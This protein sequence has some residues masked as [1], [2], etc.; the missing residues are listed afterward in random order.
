[1]TLLLSFAA[2][3]PR[4]LL[5]FCLTHF[6]WS[7]VDARSLLIKVFL[8]AAVGFGVSSLLGF[9]WIWMGFP[10]T[11]YVILETL[12]ALILTGW[13]VYKNQAALRFANRTGNW[14]NFWGVILAVGFTLF[15]ANLLFYARTY[16]HGRPDAWIN[17]NVAARFVYLGGIDWQATFLRQLDHP[18]YPLFMALTNALTWVLAGTDSV[19][20]PVAFHFVISIFT[21]GL[22]FSL[23]NLLR[24]FKQA[25][26]AAVIFISLPFTIDQGMRQYADFLLAYLLLVA[27]GLTLLYFQTKEIRLAILAGLSIGLGGWAKNEGLVSILGLTVIWVWLAL[28]KEER[29]AFRNYLLGL[30][31]PFLVTVLFKL[32]LAPSNDL[33]SGQVNG[34]SFVKLMDVTRYLTILKEM[35]L[36]LWNFGAASISLFGLI[37]LAALLLGRSETRASG[38]WLI[39]VLGIFQLL[40]Y[41]VI[42]LLTPLNLDYHLHTS[43]DRLYMHVFPLALFWFFLWL[44]S[45]QEILAKKS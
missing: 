16:P 41:F 12:A 20:S 32:F 38:G 42:Y 24:D 21:A 1:V 22:L 39:A 45:P 18:D 14:F 13:T 27:G 2:L 34:N 9:L 10:L 7:A 29:P 40:A 36:M 30:A 8:S 37:I 11:I 4:I 43:L 33:I 19:W 5:G 6:V 15:A 3:L 25:V 35:G 26:L 28:K 23:I 44:R 31:F 17:W